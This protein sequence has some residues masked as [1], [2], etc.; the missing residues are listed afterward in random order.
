MVVG[1]AKDAILAVRPY[2]SFV[3]LSFA[4]KKDRIIRQRKQA[5]QHKREQRLLYLQ[6]LALANFA[7]D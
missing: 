6:R 2:T 4:S 7:A 3:S 1:Q 5:A